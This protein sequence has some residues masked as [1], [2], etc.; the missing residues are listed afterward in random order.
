M[1]MK[2]KYIFIILIT[3]T[4]F[5]CASMPDTAIGYHL[6]KSKVKVVVNQTVSCINTSKPIVET[7]VKF[8]PIYYAG[9]DKLQKINLSELDTWYS[10]G[11]ANIT[12]SKDGRLL[13][14]G[15]DST[16]AGSEII[17]TLVSL[18]P[19]AGLESI[20]HRQPSP[21]IK[22]KIVAAC[23]IV[24][25]VAGKKDKKPLPLSVVLRSSINFTD[26][27]THSLEPF[28][29]DGYPQSLYMNIK[30]ALGII[31]YS[32][33]TSLR[34]S[35]IHLPLINS[36]KEG[37]SI[38]LVEPNIATIIIE[39][40]TLGSKK[41]QKFEAKINVP[42]WGKSYYVPIPKPPLF[43]KNLIN[44]T[45]H[46]S[47]KIKTLKYG[48]VSGIKD[49][50]SSIKALNDAYITTDKKEAKKLKDEADVIAQQQRLVVCK[51]TPKQCE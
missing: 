32:S 21:A 14:F 24:N 3:T 34:Q 26:K 30:D 33:I 47:G 50:G 43:G 39:R 19:A 36:Y 9:S 48:S 45:L 35:D 28:V 40:R 49:F 7:S 8:F 20:E 29:I 13:G 22:T 31:S 10:T 42:Q 51:A 12:L 25:M 11:N 17:D 2:L 16:G 18:V 1:I 15:A 37:R 5:G 41:I 38:M 6:P 4:F 44:L 27:N 46:E 23:N